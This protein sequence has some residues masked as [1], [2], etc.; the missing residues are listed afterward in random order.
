MAAQWSASGGNSWSTEYNQPTGEYYKMAVDNQ[1][2]YR[3]YATQMDAGSAGQL[4]EP[5]SI[6]VA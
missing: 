3:V 4:T 6:W 1:F 2:P 5:A